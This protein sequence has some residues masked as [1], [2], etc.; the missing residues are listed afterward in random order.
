MI[1]VGSDV[2]RVGDKVDSV[3]ESVEVGDSVVVGVYVV[4]GDSVGML[5]KICCERAKKD[6]CDKQSAKAA[7]WR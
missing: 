6:S 1:K 5:R 7:R 3:G 2:D 4:V